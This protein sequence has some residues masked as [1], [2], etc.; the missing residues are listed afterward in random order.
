MRGHRCQMLAWAEIEDEVE[1]EVEDDWGGLE[2]GD[3]GKKTPET[4]RDGIALVLSF[5]ASD[6]G[7]DDG[8]LVGGL[9]QGLGDAMWITHLFPLTWRKQRKTHGTV[10]HF[11]EVQEIG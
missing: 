1:F 6:L 2:E 7:G 8:D 3:Q 5:R 4:T 9:R 10:V 11:R